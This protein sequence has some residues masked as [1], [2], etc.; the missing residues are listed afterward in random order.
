MDFNKQ[1]NNKRLFSDL[2]PV[3][4]IAKVHSNIKIL[5][6]TQML[7]RLRITV[8]IVKLG[9]TIK[10]LIYEIREIIYSLYRAKEITKKIYNTSNS[11]KV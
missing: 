10:I 5:I 2:A 9:N 3:T 7:Q 1:Q 11:I 8:A 4:H 6:P